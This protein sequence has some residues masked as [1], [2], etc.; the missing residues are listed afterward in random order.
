[1][2]VLR[3]FRDR[4]LLTNAAGM[5]LVEFYC[6][7]S[8][9]I[10]DF[11]GRDETLC[12]L[13]RWILTPVVFIIEYPVGLFLLA[14]CIVIQSLK[15]KRAGKHGPAGGELHNKRKIINL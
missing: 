8:P 3:N 13:T 12:T 9:P 1:V 5:A 4:Y 15:R 14:V 11:I 10:A 6:K 2:S 7:N